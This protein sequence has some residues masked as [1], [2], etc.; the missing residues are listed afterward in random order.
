MIIHRQ[1]RR[2]LVLPALLSVATLVRAQRP[3]K[4]PSLPELETSAVRDSLDPDAQFRLA[5]GYAHKKRWDDEGRALRGAI[6]INPRYTPAYVALAFLPFQRRPALAREVQKRKVPPTWRDSLVQ[7]GRLLHQAFLIDPL[8]ELEPPDIDVQREGAALAYMNLALAL[9]F[10]GRPLDS[11]PSWVLWYRGLTAGRVGR[12]ASAIQDLEALLRRGEAIESDSVTPFPVSTNEYRYLLAVLCDRAGRRAE[13]LSYYQETLAGDLGNYM[14]HARL[15]RL[16]VGEQLWTE[17]VT[18]G[19]RAVAANPDD[20]STVRELGQILLA[21]GRLPEAEA[22]VREAREQNPRDLGTEYV[23]GVILVRSGR[24]A[25]ARVALERF[26]ALAPPTLY[27]P[28]ID[29]AR[30]RLSAL[31]R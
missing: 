10:G 31:S 13:A 9:R 26:L 5:L 15:A 29:D 7:T 21:A 18:E 23:L 12:Y 24:T 20:G 27:G 25:E 22:A 4:L 2:L 30:Q 3:P 16:Y 19:E 14:A 28:Q 11:L 1:M 17:A 8:A 6:A